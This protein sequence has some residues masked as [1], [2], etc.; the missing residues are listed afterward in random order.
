VCCVLSVEGVGD[1]CVCVFFASAAVIVVYSIGLWCAVFCFFVF[2]LFL[3]F[4]LKYGLL[5][6][7][8]L[9]CRLFVEILLL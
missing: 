8:G 7:L 6:L 9:F 3:W 4:D 1:I 2:Y 5:L